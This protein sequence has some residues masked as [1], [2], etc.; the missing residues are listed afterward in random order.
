MQ[1]SLD[2]LFEGMASALR[3]DVLPHLADPYAR[4]Q[5]TAAIELLGNLSTRV[6]WREPEAAEALAE[7]GRRVA[8]GGSDP[9]VRSEMLAALDAELA[10]L[11]SGRFGQST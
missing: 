10:R 3:Q 9:T 7:L 1:N 8:D 6:D 2:R 4:A 5:V 11:R